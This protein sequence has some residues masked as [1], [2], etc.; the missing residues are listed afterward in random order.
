M[1]EISV[2]KAIKE[3]FGQEVYV[4][5]KRPIS[6]GDINEAYCLSL[7]D[8]NDIFMKS[9]RREN[10]DFFRAEAEG[11]RAIKSTGAIATPEMF[12]EGEEGSISYLLLSFARTGSRSPH[13]SENF[14]HNLAAMHKADTAGFVKGGAY[15]FSNDNYIGAGYQ[16]NTPK[17]SF[18][19]FFAVCR[20]EA[21]IKRAESWFDREEISRMLMFTGH[22]DRYLIEP[23]KPALLHG[24]LWGGNYIV[25]PDGEAW[26]IDPAAYV[27]HPEA[28]IAM[29]ELFGGFSREFYRA[30]LEANPMEPGYEDRRDIYN[31]YHL[32]NHL[33]LFGGSYLSAVKGILRRY[34]GI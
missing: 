24:D 27:G 23:E 18:V 21:Q 19:E 5:Q 17:D 22:L 34:G 26:L 14:G 10:R 6:G 7:S 13:M 8:G 3:L 16:K 4:R 33:N 29:T 1:R 28:D 20:L 32:L 9:N 25:G 31:L 15:G 11:L 2:D 12:A 30:Y